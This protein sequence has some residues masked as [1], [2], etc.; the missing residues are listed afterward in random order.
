MENAIREIFGNS[1]VVSRT[2]GGYVAEFGGYHV[3]VTPTAVRNHAAALAS[4]RTSMRP[5]GTAREWVRAG[6]VIAVDLVPHPNPTI[7]RRSV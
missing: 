4:I 1:C 3:H 5:H 7:E 6:Y 2:A